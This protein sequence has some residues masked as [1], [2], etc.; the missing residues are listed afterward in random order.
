MTMSQRGVTALGPFHIPN[1]VRRRFDEYHFRDR[2]NA[3]A[4]VLGCWHHNLGVRIVLCGSSCFGITSR[5][6]KKIKIPCAPLVRGSLHTVRQRHA[7]IASA[8]LYLLRLALC[9]NYFLA[10]CRRC[11]RTLDQLRRVH[12]RS[13]PLG[14]QCCTERP[15]GS[16]CVACPVGCSNHEMRRLSPGV[17]NCDPTNW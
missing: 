3:A 2:L 14:N 15:N 1:I 6:R 5:V 12:G 7:S 17:A 4:T 10:I 11:D 16:W 8:F 9:R 13:L